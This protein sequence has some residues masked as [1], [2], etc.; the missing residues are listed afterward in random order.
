MAITT[1]RDPLIMPYRKR[2]NVSVDVT[3]YKP[4][5]L[6]RIVELIKNGEGK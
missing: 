3:D 4:V 1:E 5:S 6:A 2:V